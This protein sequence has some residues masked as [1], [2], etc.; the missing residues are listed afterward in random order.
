MMYSEFE[1]R[2]EIKIISIRQ[3]VVFLVNL[4][5]KLWFLGMW[6]LKGKEK[7]IDIHVNK[8]GRIQRM[9]AHAQ[10]VQA[11]VY[12]SDENCNWFILFMIFFSFALF[13]AL[14]LIKK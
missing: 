13:L 10:G 6:K 12:T 2:K 11:Y 8:E 4:E 9:R 3:R 14:K 7:N 5:K 1:S